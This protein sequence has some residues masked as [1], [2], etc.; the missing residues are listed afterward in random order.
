MAL[1]PARTNPGRAEASIDQTGSPGPVAANSGG[2]ASASP[3]VPDVPRMEQVIQSSVSDQ[4]FMGSVLV[5]RANEIIL[6]K[7]YGFANLEWSIPNSPSTKF[8]LGV[9]H[10]AVHR[11]FDPAS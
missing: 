11:G 9:D 1:A 10:Q 7:G 3:A 5:A 6:D 4:Q 2:T 8:R